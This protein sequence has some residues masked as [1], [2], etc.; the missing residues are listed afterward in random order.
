MKIELM[1][2]A[3]R[4]GDTAYNLTRTLN[5]IATCEAGTDLLV[6][7]ETHLSGFVGADELARGGAAAL[8]EREDL[9]QHGLVLAQGGGQDVVAFALVGKYDVEDLL[10]GS[11]L[12]E[13]V[14]Q[15]GL[16]GAGPGPG[17]DFGEAAFVDVHDDEAAFFG[18]GGG[19]APGPVAAAFFEGAEPGARQH[20]QEQQR[21]QRRRH[22]SDGQAA[23]RGAGGGGV[24]AAPGGLAVGVL[25]ISAPRG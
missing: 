21:Q 16:G 1:Q 6:F 18:V 7:P 19:L 14:D 11:G 3:G 25:Q 24:V 20:L 22:G 17:A 10:A 12:G 4:D 9:S 23:V 5:A 8:F 2:L 15:A 13:P